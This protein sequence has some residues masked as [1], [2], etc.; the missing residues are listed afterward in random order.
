MNLKRGFTL[1]ELLVAMAIF[2]LAVSIALVA[3]IGSNSMLSKSEARA[4]IVEGSRTVTDSLKRQV[5]DSAYD[6]VSIVTSDGENVGVMTKSYNRELAQ[7]LC[8]VT[9]RATE[10]SNSTTGAISYALSTTGRYIATWIF[11][12]NS[13]NICETTSM[14]DYMLFQNRLT[15]SNVEVTT[16]DISKNDIK[17]GTLAMLRYHLNLR[18]STESGGNTDEAKRASIEVVSALPIGLN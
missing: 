18:V 15:D 12:L 3:T 9:G 13:A 4:A 7:N 1:I 6:Q 2:I 16:F 11:N 5:Q 8:Q 14:Q 10:V 17:A